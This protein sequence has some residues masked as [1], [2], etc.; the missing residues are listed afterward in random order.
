MITTKKNAVAPAIEAQIKGFSRLYRSDHL[1]WP[2]PRDFSI[3]TILYIG[4]Y[5]KNVHRL[6]Y[7]YYLLLYRLLYI[8]LN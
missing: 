4:C 3:L 1:Y 8:C 7:I 2:K 5:E 6:S